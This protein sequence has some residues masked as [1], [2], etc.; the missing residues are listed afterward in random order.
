MGGMGKSRA[1]RKRNTRLTSL[2]GG[3]TYGDGWT[4]RL[5]NEGGKRCRYCKVAPATD[6]C[7]C[8]SPECKAK[9]HAAIGGSACD[10]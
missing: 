7:H 2:P 9:F 1:K 10:E 4:T 8:G 6:G 3:G 5:M